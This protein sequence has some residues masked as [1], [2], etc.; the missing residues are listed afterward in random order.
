M[1]T[2]LCTLAGAGTV[3]SIGGRATAWTLPIA[4]LA[5]AHN[6]V[7][8]DVITVVRLD[9]VEHPV[10]CTSHLMWHDGVVDANGP[11]VEEQIVAV[12]LRKLDWGFLKALLREWLVRRAEPVHPGS[13]QVD[14][15]RG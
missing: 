3:R 14:Q 10:S 9:R 7:A 2:A 11:V 8:S 13:S 1:R 6:L 12:R 15:A 4:V 5:L